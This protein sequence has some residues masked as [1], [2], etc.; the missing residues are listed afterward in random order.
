MERIKGYRFKTLVAIV[1]KALEAIFELMMPLMM[2]RLIDEGIKF[3][4]T[5]IIKQMALGIL[6]LTI[7]G[8]IASVIC[9]LVSAQV[10]HRIGYT[11]RKDLMEKIQTFAEEDYDQFTSSVLVNR[12]TIDVNNVQEMIN[13][14]MRLGFRAPILLIGSVLALS[15]ISKK[16]ALAL[17]ISLP[18]FLLVVCL[19]MYLSL[20][21]HRSVSTFIDSV[22]EKVGESLAGVRIIRAFSKN[23]EDLN[24]FEKLNTKLRLKQ[25]YVGAIATLSSPLTSLLMNA[26]L[27]LLVYM[28][29]VE[30]NV[31]TMTQGQVIAVINYCTQ[32]VLTLIITMNIILI[33]SKGLVSYKRIKTVLVKKVMDTSGSLC[34][35]DENLSLKFDAVSYNYLGEK[36]KV[37]H[38]VSF[39]LNPG[40]VLAIVGLTGSGKSTLVR[41]IPRLNDATEGII[42]INKHSIKD[43]DINWLRSK[44]GYISQSAQFVKGSIQDNILM[45]TGGDARQ[46]LIDAQGIDL[47]EK[48][49][50]SIIEES[51]K[52][53][54][55]GQ[56]QRI[57]IARAL[58]KKPKIL[59]FDDSFSALDALTDKKLRASLSENYQDTSQIIIS[60]RT[61]T[62]AHADEILVLDKGQVVDRGTHEELL[63]NSN[64]YR[65][66]HE[67]QNR[68]GNSDES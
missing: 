42:S 10:A 45:G 39:E 26:V 30:I 65:T 58:V 35:D 14:V 54:S 3:K 46:A 37:I 63:I 44:I 20:K 7:F 50:D 52:N 9:Q 23:E 53:L 31:G 8:Y 61:Q 41:L 36:R 18:V 62:V 66:I 17:L 19:F 68:G 15:S 33:T 48:G 21:G 51:G 32:L 38:N 57:N 64:L 60:Q 1:T 27:I 24:V 67:I 47:L 55:G 2:A 56:R 25:R 28:S 22:G 59:I 43:L 12:L 40:K 5:N 16:L 13:R 34:L 6:I 4:D 29:A 49:M 11:L